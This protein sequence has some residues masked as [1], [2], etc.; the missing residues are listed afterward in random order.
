MELNKVE[1]GVKLG[2]LKATICIGPPGSGKST[3]AREYCKANPGWYMVERDACRKA[4]NP[5]DDPEMNF[6]SHWSFKDEEHVTGLFN[7]VVAD[8]FDIRGN[9]IVADTNLNPGHRANLIAALESVGY[10]VEIKLFYVEYKKLLEY[11]NKRADSVGQQTVAKMYF[12]MLEQF[13][14]QL[15]FDKVKPKFAVAAGQAAVIF[16][17]DG[18][19]AHM[20]RKKRSPFEWD[21]VE[22][23]T[24]DPVMRELARYFYNEGNTIIILSGRDG[25]CRP[26][27]ESWLY[28]NHIPFDHL[29]M[30][31]VGDT[32]T[33]F[34]V[35]NELFQ[36]HVN[37]VYEVKA[38]FD[39]L[40]QV[41]RLGHVLGV[42]MFAVG[43][44]HLEF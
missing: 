6:W 18:T 7:E 38:W 24:P 1:N 26:E 43:N 22:L 35:K 39:D 33:D 25:I 14:D 36:E 8:I 4:L 40:P 29:Y 10:K 23:D 19:L 21:K 44:Q 2:E 3:W 16:D 37:G 34:I 11:D 12:Q 15:G 42:K 5:K 41:V 20:D 31:D 30:R 28:N 27:T 32:R 9:I 13:G 17:V